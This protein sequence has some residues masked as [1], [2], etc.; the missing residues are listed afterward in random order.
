M[1]STN[2]I[3]I[4]GDP[5][6][7]KPHVYKLAANIQEWPSILPHYRYV[8]VLEQ[9]RRHKVAKFGARRGYFPVYWKARQNLYPET[10]RITFEHTGGI[11]R[12]MQ[13]EWRMQPCEGGLRVTIY[14]ELS[15]PIPVLGPLF[16]RNVVGKYF[17]QHIAD[18]TLQ[19]F[20]Q[21]L[22]GLH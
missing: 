7:L 12:R 15:Y 20:K 8:R 17:V 19:C 2:E 13:V 10:S 11:T 14:H 4:L 3:T 9:S 6:A 18:Q 16:A 21:L 5:D 22:E 1:Q